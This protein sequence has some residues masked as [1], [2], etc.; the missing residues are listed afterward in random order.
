LRLTSSGGILW[1]DSNAEEYELLYIT[2]F[3]ASQMA[4]QSP[5]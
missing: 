1:A 5:D 2:V 3:I 4:A